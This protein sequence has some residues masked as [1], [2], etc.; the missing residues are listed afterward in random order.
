[1]RVEVYGS[2][3]SSAER[4]KSPLGKGLM[5]E[6]G[7][8]ERIGWKLS[9]DKRSTRWNSAVLN[10][11]WTGNHYTT[12]FQVD[13]VGY[14]AVMEREMGQTTAR[15][16]KQGNAVSFGSNR[17]FTL[18]SDYG[19]TIIFIVPCEER[20]IEPAYET[21]EYYKVVK[22]GIEESYEDTPHME[23]K[24]LEV[25]EKAVVESQPKAKTPPLPEFP[26]FLTSSPKRQVG[27]VSVR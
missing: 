26:D 14:D 11:A 20:K 18:T 9:F 6:L 2:L 27:K 8:Q 23:R 19:D 12:V 22:K 7:K 16:W 3:L 5:R 4:V 24:N 10:L 13:T 1:M 21:D 25:L 17:P 15:R